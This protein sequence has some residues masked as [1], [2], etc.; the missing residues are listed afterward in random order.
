MYRVHASQQILY[1]TI[2][3]AL[4]PNTTQ[5]PDLSACFLFLFLEGRL[6]ILFQR[7]ILLWQIKQ[8]HMVFLYY[9]VH[10]SKSTGT[11]QIELM[12]LFQKYTQLYVAD[13]AS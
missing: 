9:V 8:G 1:N 13:T 2:M 4:I 10:I 3:Q 7:H 6:S 5:I 11:I 12:S